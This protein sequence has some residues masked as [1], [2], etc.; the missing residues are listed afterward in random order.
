MMTLDWVRRLAGR[1]PSES[2]Q[3]LGICLDN[4]PPAVPSMMADHQIAWPVFCDGQGWQGQLVRSLGINELPELWIVDRDG[5]LR[6]LD[7][8]DDAEAVIRKAAKESGE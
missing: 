6:T 5:V 2:I 1:F 4:N 8:K 7:A 3:T